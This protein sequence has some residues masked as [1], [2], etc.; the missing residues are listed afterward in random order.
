MYNHC[1]DFDQGWHYVA[2]HGT[3][4][5]DDM[6]SLV[7]PY[8]FITI[9]QV[10]ESLEYIYTE[11][12]YAWDTQTMIEEHCCKTAPHN[13]QDPDPLQSNDL[14]VSIKDEA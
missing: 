11:L 13:Q 9:N 10:P 6:K 1:L 5:V 14:S 8:T 7:C 4:Y 12:T 3:T 2:I